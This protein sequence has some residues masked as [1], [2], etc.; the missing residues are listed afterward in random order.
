MHE[1][2]EIDDVLAMM[3]ECT[4]LS[5]LTLGEACDLLRVTPDNA[6]II[7]AHISGIPSYVEALTGYP[8]S[9]TKGVGCDGMVRQLCR[10]I[11]LLWFNPDGS[12]A[13]QLTR[14]INALAKATKALV[15]ADGEK[16]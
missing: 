5:W 6:A 9:C 4:Y 14:A 11:L 1:L 12:D 13:N 8:A 10:F 3:H 7:N 15:I 2:A 16:G